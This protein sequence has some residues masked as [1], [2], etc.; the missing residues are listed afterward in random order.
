VT[1]R[2]NAGNLAET[3]GATMEAAFEDHDYSRKFQAL[4]PLIV[5]SRGVRYAP[6]RAGGHEY[7]LMTIEELKTDRQFDLILML[8]LIEHVPDPTAILEKAK[9]LL[10]PGGG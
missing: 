8:N 6:A 5:D 2:G 9:T 7:H 10:R 1:P 4:R 3:R